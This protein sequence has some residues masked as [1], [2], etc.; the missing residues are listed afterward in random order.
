MHN[1]ELWQNPYSQ[2]TLKNSC[3]VVT[4]TGQKIEDWI[5]PRKVIDRRHENSQVYSIKCNDCEARY[6]SETHRPLEQRIKEHKTDLRYHREYS[7]WI[8][9]RDELRHL[10]NW[11][12]AKTVINNITSKGRRKILESACIKTMK[13]VINN[14]PGFYRINKILAENIFQKYVLK[15]IDNGWVCLIL[16]NII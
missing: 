13:G 1:A 7:A 14:K 4:T 3:I 6:F 11:D 10:P 9:H 12:S 16:F 2:K 5:R 8:K 15:N